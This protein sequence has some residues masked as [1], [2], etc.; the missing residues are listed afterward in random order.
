M[1]KVLTLII[2]VPLVVL[3]LG[4]AVANRQIVTVS[5]DPF[6]QASPAAAASLPLFILIFVLLILG[7]LIGGVAAWLK[8][9]KWRKAARRLDAEARALHE[10]IDAL[11]RQAM[12]AQPAPMLGEGDRRETL[13]IPPPLA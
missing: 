12:A 10:E 5:F 1:R 7:V 9:A 4:F 3:L 8:Q 13:V 6:D 11:R 2:V